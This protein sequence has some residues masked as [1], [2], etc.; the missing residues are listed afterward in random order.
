MTTI[1]RTQKMRLI[2]VRLGR[3]RASSSAVAV[4]PMEFTTSLR[5]PIRLRS[6]I[7]RI[8]AMIKMVINPPIIQGIIGINNSVT[9]MERETEARSVGPPQGSRFITPAVKPVHMARTEILMPMAR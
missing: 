5:I 1:A 6:R 4:L 3:L 7:P 9:S 8:K 2:T